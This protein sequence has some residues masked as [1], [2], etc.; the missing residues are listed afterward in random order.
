MRKMGAL[1]YP[2]SSAAYHAWLDTQHNLLPSYYVQNAREY[3]VAGSGYFFHD[4]TQ[5]LIFYA[6]ID[7]AA[8]QVREGE[9]LKHCE[10]TH[11][12]ARSKRDAS[13]LCRHS[14]CTGSRLLMRA[15]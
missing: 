6:P 9:S 4:A 10:G 7:G 15:L 2:S 12:H 13:A 1:V 3:V 8:P 14:H 5:G 11:T